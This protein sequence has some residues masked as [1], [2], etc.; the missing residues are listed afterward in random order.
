MVFLFVAEYLGKP[1]GI[2]YILKINFK[3]KRKKKGKRYIIYSYELDDRLC[4]LKKYELEI[5]EK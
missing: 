5:D 4:F 1:F 2:F 3:I